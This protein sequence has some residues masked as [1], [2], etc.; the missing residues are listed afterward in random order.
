MK[1]IWVLFLLS[2]V[3]FVGR[4]FLPVHIVTWQGSYEVFAHMWVGFLLALTITTKGTLRRICIEL[5]AA[6]SL[7]EALAFNF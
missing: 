3:A 7:L 2:L 6:L 4:F 1:I 5:L